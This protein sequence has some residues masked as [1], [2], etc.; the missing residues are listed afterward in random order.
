MSTTIDLQSPSKRCL[1]T[2]LKK[3]DT[4]SIL[5]RKLDIERYIEFG[6]YSTWMIVKEGSTIYDLS[7]W[8][9]EDIIR[10]RRLINMELLERCSTFKL[11]PKLEFYFNDCD[12]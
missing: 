7:Y 2:E 8:E 9:P 5:E 4:Q 1:A 11:V 10:Y 3:L 12:V 6:F